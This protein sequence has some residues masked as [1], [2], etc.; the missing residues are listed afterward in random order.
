MPCEGASV[1]DPNAG[2]L[3][4]DQFFDTEKNPPGRNY[5]DTPIPPKQRNL[6]NAAKAKA[7]PAGAPPIVDVNSIIRPS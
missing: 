6:A 5:K 4:V 2:V 7:K 3:A 1:G